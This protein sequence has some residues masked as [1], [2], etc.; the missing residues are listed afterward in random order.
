MNRAC[1]RFER[2]L[3]RA[4]G[5]PC[6]PA[7]VVLLSASGLALEHV[8]RLAKWGVR[9]QGRLDGTCFLELVQVPRQGE[10]LCQSALVCWRRLDKICC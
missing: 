6:I 3:L 7:S 5:R 10:D 8:H 2:G 4:T 1:G 9:W